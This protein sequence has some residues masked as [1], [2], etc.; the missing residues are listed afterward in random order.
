MTDQMADLLGTEREGRRRK[1]I[2]RLVAAHTWGGDSSDNA[3]RA[4]A[5]FL[6]L[7]Q[8]ELASATGVGRRRTLFEAYDLMLQAVE[9][10]THGMPNERPSA[11][12][13][14]AV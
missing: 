2:A 10:A 14:S 13:R 3:Q 5:L 4:P 11:R 7:L 9:Q 6:D 8:R 1:A 12:Q